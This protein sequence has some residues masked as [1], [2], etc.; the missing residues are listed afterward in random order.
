MRVPRIKVS[1]LESAA[2]YH[3]ISRTVNGERLFVDADREMFR[4][5]MWQV[6]EFCGVEVVTYAILSN[7]FHILVRVPEVAAVSDAELL[8]RYRVL[9]PQPTKYQ[10][11]RLAVLASKLAVAADTD[12]QLW[13]QRQLA[14]MGDV[15]QFMKLLKQRFSIWFNRAHQRFGTLWSER[16]KSVLVEHGA[17]LRVMAAY[18]DLNPI[19]AGL[20]TDP[21]DYRFCGYA[22][23]VAGNQ[24]LRRALTAAFE[25]TDWNIAHN[26]YR[27]LLFGSGGKKQ[28]HAASLSAAQA[29]E[30]VAEQGAL[31]VAELLRCRAKYFTDGAVLGGK[32]FVSKYL[33]R[34]RQFIGSG[35]QSP[36]RS[37]PTVS[38]G[39]ELAVLRGGRM[40]AG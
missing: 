3:C 9:H 38:G 29:E 7:H 31:S 23:A 12:G 2:L 35:K 17:A 39:D 15:S 36:P 32:V 21:K 22:E 24:R 30:V 34:Y 5:M 10:T 27:Q 18:I 19:R 11:V 40:A 20:A 37:L 6:A 8:R 14:L 33:R 26:Y 25:Q 16:F 1:P 28:R 4:R 13:R